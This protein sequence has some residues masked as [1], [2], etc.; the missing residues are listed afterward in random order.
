MMQPQTQRI[1]KARYPHSRILLVDHDQARKDGLMRVLTLGGYKN[2]APLIEPDYIQEAVSGFNPDLI[3]LDMV[4]PDAKSLERLRSLGRSRLDESPVMVVADDAT[5]KAKS[6]ALAMGVSDFL[7]KPFDACEALVRVGNLIRIKSEIKRA[8]MQS[9]HFSRRLEETVEAAEQAQI[10][11]LARMARI[12]DHADDDLSQHTWRVA[13]LAGEIA[14]EMG[15]PADDVNNIRRAARLHDLGKV[16]VSDAILLSTRA[17]TDEERELMRA[18]AS[19]GA[20]ILSGGTSPLMQLA[21]RI[22]KSHHERWDG[23]GYPEGLS[24]ASIPLEARIVAVSDAFDAMTNTRPYRLALTVDEALREIR[25]GT[26]T[27][28]DPAV[29]EAFFRVITYQPE[30]L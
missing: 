6:A 14:A 8:K 24:G 2:V 29:V 4:R 1:P 18:H 23:K 26:G 11:M 25:A 5:L 19:V 22:A 3:I 30:R 13:R 17:L 28:F 10:E 12:I 9:A 15:L 21:E 20:M 7:A 27:Q 16:V